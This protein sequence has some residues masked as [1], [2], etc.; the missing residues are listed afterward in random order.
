MKLVPFS[1][2]LKKKIVD[3]DDDCWLSYW[4]YEH[5]DYFEIATVQ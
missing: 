4:I 1:V 3:S 2:N 5:S